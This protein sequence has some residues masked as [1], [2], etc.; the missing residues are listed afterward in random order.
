MDLS[1]VREEID[2]IDSAILELLV[3]RFKLGN[4]VALAKHKQGRPLKD[5]EREESLIADRTKKLE[6]M[7]YKDPLFVRSFYRLIIDKLL[8]LEED[9]LKNYIKENEAKKT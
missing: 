3:K 8:Q 4:H 7:G 6:S 5:V 2:K 1:K 9:Y